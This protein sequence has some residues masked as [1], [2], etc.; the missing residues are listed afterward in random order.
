MSAATSSVGVTGLALSGAAAGNY[1]LASTTASARSAR[2]RRRLLTAAIVG[3]PSKTYDGTTGATLGSG[4]YSLSGFVA[5]EG[6]TVTQSSGVYA[7]ANAGTGIGVTATL[8]AGNF[9]ANGGTL[10]SNYTLPVLAAGTGTITPATLV[11]T[12]TGAVGRVYDGTTT[13]TLTAGNYL[14]SGVIGSDSVALNNPT[15]GN[16]AS[17]NVGTGIAVGVTGLALSGAAAGN[18][19]LASTTASAGIGTITPAILTVDLTGVVKKQFDGTTTA[20]LAPN[21]YTLSGLVVGDGVILNAPVLG[22]YATP[23]VGAGIPVSVSGLALGGAGAGNYVLA[24]TT[25]TGNIGE[26]F[27]LPLLPPI[28]LISSQPQPLGQY[29]ALHLGFGAIPCIPSRDDITQQVVC[30]PL[31]AGIAQQ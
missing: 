22:T 27:A 9:T 19:V 11:V 13:A 26:I 30:M 25:A 18:Y 24:S 2:S 8:A 21:N 23:D 31:L 14:L 5:G 4:N 16:Y 10:L 17:A 20:T 7:T 1:V 3:N 28:T 15:S 29:E 6:A 12:L